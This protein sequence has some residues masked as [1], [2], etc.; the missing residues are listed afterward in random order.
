LYYP[1]YE[2][3]GVD[4]AAD[5]QE[6]P[7]KFMNGPGSEKMNIEKITFPYKGELILNKEAEI[8]V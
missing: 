1:F 2:D 6:S 7:G 3:F 4:F 8:F 5:R